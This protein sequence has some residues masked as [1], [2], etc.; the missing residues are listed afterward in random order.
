MCVCV[1]VW[2][3]VRAEKGG[4]EA[5]LFADELANEERN[6]TLRPKAPVFKEP[7]QGKRQDRGPSS[8]KSVGSYDLQALR[9]GSGRET[10]REGGA[11]AATC[12]TCERA[13]DRGHK[14]WPPFYG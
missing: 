5:C 14:Q 10:V 7:R 8:H 9:R 6:S 1:C 12:A 4:R 11:E 2:K 3:E 13:F